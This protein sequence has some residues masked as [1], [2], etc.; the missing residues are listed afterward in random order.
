MVPGAQ[1]LRG[2]FLGGSESRGKRPDPVEARCGDAGGS[3]GTFSRGF[4]FPSVFPEHPGIFS[5][6]AHKNQQLGSY[7]QLSEAGSERNSQVCREHTL[8]CPR[9]C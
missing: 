4:F 1:E 3:G 5:E 9:A 7:R 2:S 8:M 6:A